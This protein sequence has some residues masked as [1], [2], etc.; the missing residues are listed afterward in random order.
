M[1]MFKGGEQG[2][3]KGD[4]IL[5]GTTFHGTIG[6]TFDG[7]FLKTFGQIVSL[8][9]P[10]HHVWTDALPMVHQFRPVELEM[11]EVPK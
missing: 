1:I 2:S 5:D 3:I 4:A 10:V 9:G 11:R 8:S 7:Y 6:K